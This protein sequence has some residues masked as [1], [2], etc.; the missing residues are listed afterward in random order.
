MY[1]QKEFI[2]SRF[3]S[4][5]RVCLDIMWGIPSIVYG[6]FALTIMI[7]VGLRGGSIVA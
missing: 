1:L 5:I 4:F 2:S 7:A 6:V 3:S